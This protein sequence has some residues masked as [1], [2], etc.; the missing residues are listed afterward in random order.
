MK[1]L[2]PTISGALLLLLSSCAS[3]DALETVDNLETERY[4]GTWYEIARL[5]NLFERDL[6]CVTAN[7]Q[8]GGDGNIIVTNRGFKT[9]KGTWKEDVGRARK[10]KDSPNSQLKVSF[11]WPFEGDYYVVA[12]GDDYE[13]AV[14]GDPSRKYFWILSRT[15]E[16]SE[17]L[18]QDLLKLGKGLGFATENVFKTP[19]NCGHSD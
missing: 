14:V 17:R 2:I 19:Q 6:T 11:F 7:Y 10:P 9:G 16:I 12:L 4:L 3:P 1:H 5:P 18:Y 13:Y 15:P 8:L